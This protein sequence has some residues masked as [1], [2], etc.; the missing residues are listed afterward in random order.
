M[1]VDLDDEEW[2]A[3]DFLDWAEEENEETQEQIQAQIEFSIK[4]QKMIALYKRGIISKDEFFDFI[5]GGSK[6]PIDDE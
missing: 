5:F 4:E 6:P 3:T 2:I 1:P